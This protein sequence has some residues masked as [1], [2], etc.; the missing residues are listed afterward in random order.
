[1][2]GG[3]LPG[4]ELALRHLAGAFYASLCHDPGRALE[5]AVNATAEYLRTLVWTGQ[6]IGEC[7]LAAVAVQNRRLWLIRYGRGAAYLLR[8]ARGEWRRLE[9]TIT[10]AT[11]LPLL[12]EPGDLVLLGSQSLFAQIPERMLKSCLLALVSSAPGIAEQSLAEVLI[13]LAGGK[14]NAA[15]SLALVLRCHETAAQQGPHPDVAPL[16][17]GCPAGFAW[18]FPALHQRPAP[19][20]ARGRSADSGWDPGPLASAPIVA[21]NQ[22]PGP[23]PDSSP[24]PGA[25]AGVPAALRL[26]YRPLTAQLPAWIAAERRLARTL[27]PGAG[28]LAGAGLVGSWLSDNPGPLLVGCSL[29][30]LLLCN[31][32]WPARTPAAPMA[33]GSAALAK[34]RLQATSRRAGG[35]VVSPGARRWESLP[36]VPR[37]VTWAKDRLLL[38]PVA[39]VD[40]GCLD[41]VSLKDSTGRIVA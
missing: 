34:S 30:G 20:T 24:A 14:P 15:A 2:P 6:D 3:A 36:G 21:A 13:R 28:V 18:D 37:P 5:S 22:Q 41:I 19:A 8:P 27:L 32:T 31:A 11:S 39:A 23:A 26:S 40:A 1:M 17:L 29:S 25:A 33:R 7:G 16:A 38:P 9:P 12:L 35:A 4:A 10:P